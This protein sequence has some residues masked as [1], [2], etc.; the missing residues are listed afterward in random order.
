MS[1]EPAVRAWLRERGA[2]TIEHPGG[3]LY[4][5]PGMGR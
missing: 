2:E 5:H 4:E 3:T 1:A